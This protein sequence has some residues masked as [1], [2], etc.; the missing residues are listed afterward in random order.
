MLKGKRNATK[1]VGS[2]ASLLPCLTNLKG[3]PYGSGE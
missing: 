2:L 3:P 1:R